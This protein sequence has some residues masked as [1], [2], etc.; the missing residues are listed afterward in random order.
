MHSVRRCF[1]GLD[2]T[3]AFPSCSAGH[4]TLYV[5][6][7]VSQAQGTR[8]GGPIDVQSIPSNEVR[9]VDGQ[10]YVQ[11]RCVNSSHASPDRTS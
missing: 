8:L 4:D 5:L 10:I 11:G 1:F 2:V 9:P 6:P 7:R 3:A